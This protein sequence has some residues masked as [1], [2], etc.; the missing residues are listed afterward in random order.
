MA[1]SMICLCCLAVGLVATSAATA[2]EPGYFPAPVPGDPA[3]LGRGVQRTMKLLATSTPEH[4]NSVRILFYGQSITNQN[5][6]NLVSD[7]LRRRFPNADLQIENRSI[8]GYSSQRLIRP[9]EHDVYPFYPDLVIFQVYGSHIDY[10]SIIRNIRSR[11]TAEILMQMDHA[12]SWPA[13]TVDRSRP[14]SE[15][16]DA[17]MNLEFLPATAK[18]YG[19]GLV[20][21][22]SGW[23]SY[24]KANNLQPKALLSDDIHLNDH[25]NYLMAALIDQYLVYRPEV[26]DQASEQMIRTVP[27]DAAAWKEGALT[28]PFEGNRIDAIPALDGR[29]TSA[30]LI[31]GQP[32]SAIPGIYSITRPQ[33]GPWQPLTVSRIDHDAPLVVEKWTLRITSVGEESKTWT[34]DVSGSVTG[35]DGSGTSESPFVSN[36]GRVRIGPKAWFRNGQVPVGYEITWDVLINGTDQYAPP[37][38]FDPAL[39]NRVILAQGLGNG[40]HTLRLV[41]SGQVPAI[42]ALRVYQPP[43]LAPTSQP[44]E[45]P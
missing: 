20:D 17:F 35:P 16:W 24:L 22:R 33:P 10:E 13:Q 43:L 5:W 19:C 14:A 36:S 28:M 12:V 30:V 3:S 41:A 11:T 25:G 2:A 23:V 39:D 6:T 40:P 42:K 4:R 15:W 32:P 34:F 7:D 37:A 45:G 29:G 38:K 21:I 26:T 9:A 27:V 31:D 44:S 8:G 18:T 1:I